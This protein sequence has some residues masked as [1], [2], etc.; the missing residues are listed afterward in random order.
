MTMLEW[1]GAVALALAVA[2][3]AVFLGLKWLFRN[4]PK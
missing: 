4:S 1:L 2:W 3:M